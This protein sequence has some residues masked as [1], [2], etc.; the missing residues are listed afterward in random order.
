L[1][2]ITELSESQIVVEAPE[3]IVALRAADPGAAREW[4]F[5]LRENLMREFAAGREIIGVTENGDYVLDLLDR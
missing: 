5:T 4:R 1:G 3:D 2:V